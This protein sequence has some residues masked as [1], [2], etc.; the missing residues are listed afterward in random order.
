ML[1]L[2]QNLLYFGHL[3]VQNERSRQLLAEY[4]ITNVTVA[5][6]AAGTFVSSHAGATELIFK[7][8]FS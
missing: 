7:H 4:G 1:Q 8:I 6:E 5:G 3:F 2:A